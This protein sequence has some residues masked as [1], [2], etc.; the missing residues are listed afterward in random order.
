MTTNSTQPKIDRAER[1]II[2][3]VSRFFFWILVVVGGIGF[4]GS[5]LIFLY[6]LIPPS[7]EKVVLDPLPSEPEVTIAEVVAKLVPSEPIAQQTKS[8]PES[9][10]PQKSSEPTAQPSDPLQ[11]KLSKLLDSLETYFPD[12]WKP[13]YGRRPSSYDW[14]GRATAYETYIT[15]QGLLN[16]INNILDNYNSKEKKIAIVQKMI[17]LCARLEAEKREKGLR[18]YIALSRDKMK[19]F[20]Q[21]VHR[22]NVENGN[23]E[24]MAETQFLSAKVEKN[25]LNQKAAI[26]IGGTFVSIALLGLVLCFL[27]IERNTRALRDLIG[28][29]RNNES[30]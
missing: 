16:Y 2:F 24:Q 26:G 23:K 13:E 1:G 3:R 22:I 10:Q 27:A 18:T 30:K 28:K 4:V 15:K 11:T 8:K 6:T 17:E 5:I 7:K 25:V 9:E 12:N 14:F 29:D 19:I 21:E 20:Q